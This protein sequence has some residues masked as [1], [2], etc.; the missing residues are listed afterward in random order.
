MIILDIFEPQ[1]KWNSADS[2]R[3]SQICFDPFQFAHGLQHFH[4]FYFNIFVEV[5]YVEFSYIS[6][7][8]EQ[9]SAVIISSK[10][11]QFD[12]FPSKLLFAHFQ[13]KFEKWINV[14]K[15]F[16]LVFEFIRIMLRMKF[17]VGFKM[18][19]Y[20]HLHGNLRQFSQV[21]C[22]ELASVQSHCPNQVKTG[23]QASETWMFQDLRGDWNLYCFRIIE[24]EILPGPW[25]TVLADDCLAGV[26]SQ[27][28]WWWS[29]PAS[30]ERFL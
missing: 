20:N 16:Q 10:L 2:C 29:D 19:N 9:C 22:V 4:I 27:S 7:S 30:R 3:K 25:V 23:Q 11:V 17:G 14:V 28:D 24:A 1:F 26:S 5:V 13:S 12:L 18:S 15:K 8:L 6:S 21:I